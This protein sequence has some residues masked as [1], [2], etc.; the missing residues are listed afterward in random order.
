MFQPSIYQERIRRLIEKFES[1]TTY[2]LSDPS[3]IHYFTGFEFLVPNERE[4]FLVCNATSVTVVHTSF[5]PITRLNFLEYLS[6]ISP[7]QLQQHL[8][9]ILKK[10]QSQ[11]LLFDPKTL[12]VAE[13]EAIKHAVKNVTNSSITNTVNSDFISSIMSKKAPEEIEQIA[14]AC[15]ATIDT[16]NEVK[17]HL[18]VGITELEVAQLIETQLRNRASKSLAF[19]TIVAF[20]PHT[21]LPHH[22][23]GD[24]KLAENMPVLV[25]MGARVTGYCA[26]M[27]RTTWF[28]PNPSDTFKKIE[29]I[30]L[31]A[32]AIAYQTTQQHVKKTVRAKDVDS[33]A[34]TH[35]ANQGFGDLFI[36]TTGHGL[37]LNIHESPSISWTNTQELTA[38]MTITIEPGIYIAG[39]LGYRYENTVLLT[40]QGC[41][42]LT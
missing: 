37:G 27:T 22:Q 33:A 30:V 23:P 19:P 10:H 4:A 18:A 11:R 29:A 3:Q 26:D 20:G 16:Y 6:G 31:E 7:T 15:T 36:H 40:A 39:E 21:A 32:Y 25:D 12:F 5:A 35:I 38:G 42:T 28:G 9:T 13:F 14:R 41:E 34:R 17:Q 1:G 8:E 24:T 2:L